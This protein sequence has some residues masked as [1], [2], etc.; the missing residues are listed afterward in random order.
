MRKSHVAILG[1]PLDLGAGR[2]GVDMGPSALRLAGLNPK[3]ESLGYTVEDL[4]N[5]PVAQQESTPTGQEN[6]KY[7]PQIAKTCAALANSRRKN[8]AGRVSFRLCSAAII[9]WR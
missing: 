5:L 3:L 9:Q 6:A 4:G 2:R 7:L 8:H 1:V